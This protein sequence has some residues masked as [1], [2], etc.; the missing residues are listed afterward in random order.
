MII[1]LS[2][3][4]IFRL[5]IV[6]TAALT[7]LFHPHI[8][9]VAANASTQIPVEQLPKGSTGSNTLDIQATTKVPASNTHGA[10]RVLCSFSHMNYDDP[11]VF[12]NQVGATHLHTFFG[13]TS[14]KAN[15]TYQSL[16]TSGNSTCRGGI[17][18]R[19]G[20]W[21]PT[22]L[23]ASGK[24]IP[25]DIMIAYYKSFSTK[26]VKNIPN[27]LRIVVGN[28]KAQSGQ[29]LAHISWECRVPTTPNQM[30]ARETYI[31]SC[32]RGNVLHHTLKFPTCWDGFNLD[33]PNH[34][35][36]M[37]YPVKSKC[38]LSH[39]VKLPDISFQ[40]SWNLKNS[41]TEGWRLSSDMYDTSLPGG[42]SAHGDFFEAWKP[43]VRNIWHTNC[44]VGSKECGM[45]LLGNGKHLA[46]KA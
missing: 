8:N 2:K 35:S 12:P 23:D 38:P 20:Y 26:I 18:D 30:L 31:P 34:Q 25:P 6:V 45:G 5:L 36:H 37:S 28:S 42:Y 1:K 21:V 9:P 17:A 15:S 13:N 24:P 32:D 3:K 16:S 46:K 43:E 39:P 7:L 44:L 41:S 29:N 19:S 14:T 33:S 22:I 4:K 11:I 40:L 10:F 27:G